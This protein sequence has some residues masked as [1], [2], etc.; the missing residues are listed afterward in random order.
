MEVRVTER[1]VAAAT[2][3]IPGDSDPA[4]RL[5]LV[6]H[7]ICANADDLR[8]ALLLILDFQRHRTDA[9][10]TRLIREAT[11]RYREELEKQLGGDCGAWPLILGALLQ[12]LLE[13]GAG[14]LKRLHLL[15]NRMVQ[16]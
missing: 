13:P 8:R 15:L 12:S 7:W 14:Y 6:C 9:W 1:D 2:A 10:A 3:E 5:Q 4:L 11:S 16:T